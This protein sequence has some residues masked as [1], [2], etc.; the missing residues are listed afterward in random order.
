MTL[1]P[2]SPRCGFEPI[3]AL[4]KGEFAS[5]AHLAGMRCL[6]L[7]LLF[8]VLPISSAV[9]QEYRPPV[10]VVSLVWGAVTIKHPDADYKPA[11]WLEPV[12]A[13]DQLRTAGDGSKLLV[14]FF[15]D[16]HQEV[17]GANMVA[18]V[19]ATGLSKTEGTG[20]IR[21]DPA[22]NPFG[23]GGVENPFV[24]Q[25]KLIQ[26]DFRG[27]DAPGALEAERVTLRARVRPAFPPSFSWPDVGA[28]SYTLEI[29][30]PTGQTT[31]KKT[32]SGTQYKLRHDEADRLP[33]GV[34][35]NWKVT[36][37]DGQ[38]VVRP[39]AF[40]LLTQPLRKWFDGQAATFNAKREK[41]KLERSDWTDYVVVCS[42]VVETDRLFE[43]A[44]KLKAMDPQNPGIYGILTRIYLARGCPAHA[45]AAH[46]K[47]VELGGRD[48]IYP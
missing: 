10:G 17:M 18:E 36:S 6:L 30:D 21:R 33:K 35:Y 41:N 14:V 45:Q 20:D 1:A 46:N 16:N 47:L 26:D 7:A 23:A 4:P 32:V 15:N 25:R 29:A 34:N 48:P 22:R 11:R 19:G 13:G 8:A 9:A 42:Q 31:W 12:F 43:L 5:G 27:A 37:S 40:R 38:V 2:P 44:E 39:Y 24:Y 3:P 28:Q